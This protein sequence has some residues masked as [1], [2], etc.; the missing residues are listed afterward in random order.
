LRRLQRLLYR[1]R[2]QSRLAGGKLRARP[3][4]QFRIDER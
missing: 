2:R 4:G 1:C 3:I